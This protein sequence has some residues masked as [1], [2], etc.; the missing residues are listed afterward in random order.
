MKTITIEKPI[1]FIK[2]EGDIKVLASAL[3]YVII[4]SYESHIN[5]TYVVADASEGDHSKEIHKIFSELHSDL[6]KHKKTYKKDQVEITY[7]KE[8]INFTTISNI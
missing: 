5:K 1:Y 2:V 3:P 8:G 6:N 7:S 4:S